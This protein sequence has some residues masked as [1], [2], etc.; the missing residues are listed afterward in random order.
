[1]QFDW[2]TFGLQIV[3]VLV[4]L[5][6]LRHFLFRP[7]ADI[8]ARR[9]ADI[10][11][12]QDAADAAQAQAARAEAVARAETDKIAIARDDMLSRAQSDGEAQRAR[13]VQAARAEADRIIADARTE[14]TRIV[15]GAQAVTLRR[16]RDL[17]ETI[18]ARALSDLPDPPTAAGFARRLA[19]ELASLPEARRDAMLGGADVRLVASTALTDGDLATTRSVLI[20]L[21]LDH[22]PIEVDPTLISGLELRSS[23]GAIHNSLAHDL[24]RIS[25]ALDNDD[26]SGT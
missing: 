11:A 22:A 23:T 26:G 15:D 10:V 18:A 14:A 4:L 16:A 9:Q 13:L 3:N 17:A 5:A 20:P 24:T 7:V 8:I 19:A 6:I 2:L 25:E 1:M 21:G 12:A